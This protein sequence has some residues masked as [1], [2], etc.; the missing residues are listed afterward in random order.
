MTT[1]ELIRD[2]VRENFGDSEADDP[3][4]SLVAMA[5]FIDDHAKELFNALPYERQFDLVMEWDFL[6][7]WTELSR[8]QQRD[9]YDTWMDS[10]RGHA[11]SDELFELVDEKNMDNEIIANA[12]KLAAR[13]AAR[14]T[15]S[16]PPP[17][18]RKPRDLER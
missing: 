1:E 18:N 2:W 13:D 11:V 7:N 14:Q 3:S 6:E 10:S 12:I 16:E 15:G 17:V 8:D 9:I 5:E 4:W